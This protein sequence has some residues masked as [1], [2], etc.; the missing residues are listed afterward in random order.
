MLYR[1]SDLTSERRAAFEEYVGDLRERV[2]DHVEEL[3]REVDEDA[4]AQRTY[5]LAFKPSDA[6]PKRSRR[7]KLQTAVLADQ[8]A[9]AFDLA[10]SRRDALVAFTV[11]VQEHYDVLDDVVDGDVAP[12]HEDEAVVVSQA[13]VPLCVRRLDALG[14]DAVEYW[15]DCALELLAAPHAETTDDPSADAYRRV[16]DRQSALF[17]LVTGLAAVAADRDESTVERADRL[18]RT[19]YR[20]AQFVLDYEQHARGDDE[21]NARALLGERRVLESLEIWRAAVTDLTAEFPTHAADRLRA[22]VAL[23]VDAWQR[24]LAAKK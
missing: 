4:L 6:L 23:D 7:P 8:T 15:H 18:G 21:W 14:S 1:P 16:I 13:L 17:G 22:L 24:E 11:A 3:C 19:V 9:A 20:H 10:D 2:L 5:E 12:G